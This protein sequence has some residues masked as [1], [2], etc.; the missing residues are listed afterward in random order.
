[1]HTPCNLDHVQIQRCSSISHPKQSQ[2]REKI[3]SY[4]HHVLKVCSSFTTVLRCKHDAAVGWP[5]GY[6]DGL[7]NGRKAWVGGS[8]PSP[9]EVLHLFLPSL[10]HLQICLFMPSDYDFRWQNAEMTLFTNF[11]WIWWSDFFGHINA[12]SARNSRFRAKWVP[13]SC[14]GGQTTFRDT[15]LAKSKFWP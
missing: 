3:R 4:L 7:S 14:S 13:Y 8:G 1:M 11:Q 5:T 6:D 2:I 12:R 10:F 15:F 9:A